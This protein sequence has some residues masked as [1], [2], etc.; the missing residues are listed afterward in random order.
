MIKEKLNVKVKD[1]ERLDLTITDFESYYPFDKDCNSYQE[2][3]LSKEESIK[4]HYRNVDKW[5]KDSEIAEIWRKKSK[6]YDS[7]IFQ[8]IDDSDLTDIEI[9]F[10]CEHVLQAVEMLVFYV[11]ASISR[12]KDFLV[13]FNSKKLQI[14]PAEGDVDKIEDS[15]DGLFVMI[16][17]YDFVDTVI[18]NIGKE[19]VISIVTQD[20]DDFQAISG[21]SFHY[22]SY[23]YDEYYLYEKEY[24]RI[25]N[26]KTSWV[27]EL[28]EKRLTRKE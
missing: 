14:Y 7:L 16:E 12:K 6:I 20:W 21:L 9:K 17:E 15:L 22:E 26:I 3:W 28:E 19:N 11:N 27:Y 23:D 5:W 24:N 10:K 25:R 18:K 2:V 8:K 4:I 1:V 13:K